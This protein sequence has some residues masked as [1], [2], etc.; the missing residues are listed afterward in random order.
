MAPPF[1][2]CMYSLATVR[3]PL[4]AYLFSQPDKPD[5]E[6]KQ[7]K[8]PVNCG[9]KACPVESVSTGHRPDRPDS[10]AGFPFVGDCP[11]LLTRG[12]VISTGQTG[13]RGKKLRKHCK[14]RGKTLSGRTRFNRTPSGQTGQPSW[15]SPGTSP[16]RLS[17]G[18]DFF[19]FEVNS[20][21]AVL[22]P[23][24]ASRNLAILHGGKVLPHLFPKVAVTERIAMATLAAVVQVGAVELAFGN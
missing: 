15:L 11:V 5:R 14:L 17:V 1:P 23:L 9:V 19:G 2:I 3:F 22:P 24:G 20:D 16:K 12:V 13:Q 10:R 7:I 8:N 6:E 4:C 18:H 21:I